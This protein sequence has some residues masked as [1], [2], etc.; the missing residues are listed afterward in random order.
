[1]ISKGADVN[2]FNTKGFNPLILA[3]K[4]CRPGTRAAEKLIDAG[5]SLNKFEKGRFIG[6]NAFDIAVLWKND[7]AAK[8]LDVKYKQIQ[9]EESSQTNNNNN[10]NITS[11]DKTIKNGR[12]KAKALCP[13]CN[14]HVKYP[15]RMSF[16]QFNQEQAEKE[17]YSALSVGDDQKQNK[18]SEIYITRK[19][20][21]QFL[22]HNHGET[23]KK[24]CHIEYHGVSNM[25]KLRKEISESYSIL[26]A[27]QKCWHQLTNNSI[28]EC[29]NFDS[30]LAFKN[31]FLIDLCSGKGLTAALCDV[32]FSTKNDG[33]YNNYILA[34]DKMP[35]HMV[36]HFLQNDNTKYLSRD[37]MSEVFFKELEKEVH[38]QSK[39]GRT[40]ILVGMHLCGN[41]SERAIDFFS[42][43]S[44]IE[45]IVLSPCCLPK[46]RHETN[47]FITQAIGDEN[48][49]L[50]WSS[51]LKTRISQIIDN[52]KDN[53]I[54][55]KDNE[56]H[57]SKNTIIAATRLS[58]T[59]DNCRS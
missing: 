2:F 58:S 3:I 34:V 49:Y 59:H 51:Y 43:I 50:E 39:E 13:L 38:H 7:E 4:H 8:I 55:Y 16:L 35:T 48:T 32:L 22:S 25:H 26:H 33:A 37:I 30:Q 18:S 14:C 21:D 10:N 11:T 40:I 24:L 41:L 36:P 5:A 56:M 44:H 1:M 27:V 52:E 31:T 12:S 54:L 42:K 20:L 17:Y 9:N 46:L 29:P 23:Y 45:A 15:T 19:Y 57:S 53:V 28:D 6:L 47:N